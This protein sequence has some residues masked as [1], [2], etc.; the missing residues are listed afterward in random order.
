MPPV[1]GSAPG[2]SRFRA[3][4]D[5]ARDTLAAYAGLTKTRIIEQLLVV[6]MP[7]MF[8]AQR[9]IP[10]IWLILSTLFGGALAAASAHALN[11]VVDA[12]IDKVMKRTARRP[13]A[14]G[15]VPPRNAL[16]FGLALGAFSS[17]WLGLTTNWLA[18]ALSVLAIAFYVLVYTMLLKR[19]TSQNIVWGGAAGCMPV[20]IGWAAVTGTVEWP[21]LIMFG[22]IFFWTPPHFWALAMRYREDYAAAG[23]PML[24]VVATPVQVSRRIVAYSWVM[25]VVTLL[26]LPV[27]SWIYATVAV[28]LGAWFV[29]SA[30]RM[31]HGIVAGH[32]VSP[33]KLFHLSNLYLC[34][35]FLAIA[36][37]AAVGLPVLGLPF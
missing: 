13:L 34:G 2:P 22:I 32:E 23:V 7:A 1:V 37:D 31:Q 11:C 8:L 5:R 15:Q 25:I 28:L 18:A 17:V 19:R 16:I 3:R 30:H 9:G 24:P 36:V 4:L 12:D 14:K 20:V 6:T 35:L 21:A 26:L 29:F 10:S 27:T 33:M